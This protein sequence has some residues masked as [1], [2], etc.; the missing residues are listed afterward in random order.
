M[1]HVVIGAGPVGRTITEQLSAS[2]H[3][4]RLLTRSGSGPDH[5]LVDRRRVDAADPAALR[6]ALEGAEAVFDCMHASAYDERVWRVE[7]PAAERVVLA[8]AG[9]VGAVVVF[10]ES[11]YAYTRTDAP[12][13]ENDP[14][15]R[16]EGKGAVRRDLLR[17][18]AESATD[19]VSVAASDF[20]GPHVLANGHMGER[21][22]TPVLE[23]GTLRVL[24]SLDQPH[25][26]T[27]VPDLAAAMVRAAELPDVRGQVVHAPTNPPRSQREVVTAYAETVGRPVPRL[28]TIPGWLLTMAGRVHRPTRELVAMSYQLDGPFVLD[29]T[30]SERR[31]DLSPTPWPQVI[32]ETMAWWQTRR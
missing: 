13:T 24:G 3:E 23:G 6:P 28:G 1:V 12:M 7:L 10:P 21:A 2:G 20:I 19:T 15:D 8:A 32:A 16:P 5:P 31:L 17:V 18:R 26:W 25:S 11:L 27:Y 30:L 14:R 4:V 29:S 22:V 9:E